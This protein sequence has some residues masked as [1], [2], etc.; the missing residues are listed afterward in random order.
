VDFFF[1]AGTFEE[2]SL[3][4]AGSLSCTP[5]CGAEVCVVSGADGVDAVELAACGDRAEASARLLENPQSA[6]TARTHQNLRTN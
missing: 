6:P 3:F 1:A 2:D 5:E 4:F